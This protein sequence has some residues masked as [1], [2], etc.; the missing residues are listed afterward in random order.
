[1]RVPIGVMA[2][3]DIRLRG[4]AFERGLQRPLSR[5][6]Y[7]VLPADLR[8]TVGCPTTET[9]LHATSNASAHGQLALFYKGPPYSWEGGCTAGHRQSWY[10]VHSS[11][12]E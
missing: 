7:A 10:M 4:S 11:S 3:L 5:Y 2:G 9:E 1:M 6:A 12:Y 8:C